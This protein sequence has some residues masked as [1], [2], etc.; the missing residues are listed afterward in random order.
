MS[1]IPWRI[2]YLLSLFLGLS[3]CASTQPVQYN[4]HGSLVSVLD[5]YS[6]L[7]EDHPDKL[8]SFFNI[9]EAVKADVQRELGHYHKHVRGTKLAQWL[10]SPKGKNMLYD[11]DANLTP[12]QVYSQRRGN[13]LS[14]TLLL[15][16]LANELDLELRINQ[17]DL[18]D[19]WGQSVNQDL[20]FYRHVNAF[21]KT[22]RNTYI[23]DIALQN[24]KPGYP[25]RLLSNKQGAALLFSN[26]GLQFMQKNDYDSA[27]HYLKMSA[28]LYPNNADMWINLGAVFKRRLNWQLAEISYLKA[29]SLD[30]SSRLAASNL[31]RLYRH[32]GQNKKALKYAKLAK[33]ARLKNPYLRFNNAKTAFQEKRFRR[34]SSEIRNAIKLHNDDP[35][36][37][38]LSSR[39]KQSQ[40]NYIAALKDLETAYKLS[41]NSDER[42]RYANKVDMV[43]ERIKKIASAKGERSNRREYEKLQAELQRY[44]F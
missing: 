36:F 25:Q 17:V 9:P 6:Q 28:S 4:N 39:I 14:F 20:V 10:M 24:Y 19:M 38:E 12:S 44:N 43:I 2:V 31:D 41:N 16:Q 35:Q 23:F 26:V 13:C 27:L 21:H 11:I 33:I 37:F 18:P 29:F 3:A 7:P 32:I 8:E 40:A 1:K 42:K 34:A 15:I 5:Y 30:D 22:S